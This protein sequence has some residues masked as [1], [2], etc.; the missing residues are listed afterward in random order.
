MPK[1]DREIR[2]KETVRQRMRQGQPRALPSKTRL[3]RAGRLKKEQSEH[4]TGGAGGRMPD[5]ERGWGAWFWGYLARLSPSWNSL[6]VESGLTLLTAT[7]L[8]QEKDWPLLGRC[9]SE[10]QGNGKP[11]CFHKG[12]EVSQ[13]PTLHTRECLTCYGWGVTLRE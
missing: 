13:P 7:C 9:L 10:F 6:P 4:E 1:E 8:F 11:G 5:G 2:E 3:S 12:S